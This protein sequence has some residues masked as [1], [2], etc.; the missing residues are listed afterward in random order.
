[1][2]IGERYR[3]NLLGAI[4]G[5][6]VLGWTL[7]F[8]FYGPLAFSLLGEQAAWGTHAFVFGLALGYV[9]CAWQ[10]RNTVIPATLS[11][12]MSVGL[13]TASLLSPWALVTALLMM[14]SGAATVGPTL[15]WT[16]YLADTKKRVF[17][18][19]AGVVGA[20]L[21][22]YVA[23]IAAGSPAWSYALVGLTAVLFI[24]ASVALDREATGTTRAEA[25]PWPFLWPLL[26]FILVSSYVGGLLYGAIIP[27]VEGWAGLGWLSFWPYIMAFIIAGFLASRSY[28]LLP[29][30]T[31]T[32]YGLAFLPLVLL[33]SAMVTHHWITSFIGVTVGAAFADAFI[34]LSLVY[35]ASRGHRRVIP[36][37][38]ALNV[39]VIWTV[40][41]LS[42]LT[43]LSSPERMPMASLFSAGLLFVL[44]PVII[45]RLA[46]SREADREWSPDTLDVLK[47]V[48]RPDVLDDLT[49]AEKRVCE[50]LLVGKTNRAIGEDLFISINTVKF[51]VRNILRKSGCANRKVLIDRL[52]PDGFDATPVSL[53]LKSLDE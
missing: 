29:A 1:M 8:P 15:A 51:H 14:F 41:A 23:T 53:P 19:I 49:D 40:S 26:L 48:S 7:V 34:W 35:L 6:G 5:L 13:V 47:Q 20:N 30:V 37:G 31:L 43:I 39:F 9:L 4:G 28:E 44:I 45:T 46:P 24:T 12:V 36:A 21:L 42:D 17:P 50:L 38:L 33:E 32:T 11:S 22:C 2:M 18:F 3:R 25:L 10:G 16:N 52:L 27:A